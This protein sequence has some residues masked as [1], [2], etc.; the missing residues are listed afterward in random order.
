MCVY[1]AVKD[2]SYLIL[3]TIIVVLVVMVVIVCTAYFTWSVVY[4]CMCFALKYIITETTIE[5]NMRPTVDLVEHILGKRHRV[6]NGHN[7]I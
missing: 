2:G 5:Y 3:N 7:G 1:V 6:Q 4:M